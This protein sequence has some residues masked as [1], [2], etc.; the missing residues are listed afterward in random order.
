MGRHMNNAR[1]TI[2]FLTT[3]VRSCVPKL[4]AHLLELGHCYRLG[5]LPGL[6]LPDFFSTICIL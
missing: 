1:R 6:G 3:I 5:M 4:V 2:T